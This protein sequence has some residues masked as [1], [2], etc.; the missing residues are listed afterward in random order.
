M[1]GA[2]RLVES[3]FSPQPATPAHAIQEGSLMIPRHTLAITATLALLALAPLDS[4]AVACAAGVYHAGCVG[5]N[6]A[7]TVRKPAPAY[8]SPGNVH[9][10]NGVNRAGCAGPNGATVIRK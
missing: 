5:P 1:A 2:R 4:W 6:G 9:C 7:A 10:A 8:H 3:D